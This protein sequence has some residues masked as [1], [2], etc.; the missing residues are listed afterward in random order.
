MGPALLEA[1]ALVRVTNRRH[2]SKVVDLAVPRGRYR[3]LVRSRSATPATAPTPSPP[4]TPARRINVTDRRRQPKLS[5]R[6][7]WLRAPGIEPVNL[8]SRQK[9]SRL[10]TV[11][12][13]GRIDQITTSADH[14]VIPAEHRGDLVR[15]R[16]AAGE[17]H[18]RS[19]IDLDLTSYI[20][21]RPPGQ[22]RRQQAR[23]HRLA[24]RVPASQVTDHRQCRDHARHADLLPDKGKSKDQLMVWVAGPAQMSRP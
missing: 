11:N 6:T 7:C 24:R 19:V 16:G 9:R 12:R 2:S 5:L 15:R 4:A 3:D 1:K 21:P 18:Q 23:A 10:D 17:P 14:D 8:L 20:Q 22:L 13:L